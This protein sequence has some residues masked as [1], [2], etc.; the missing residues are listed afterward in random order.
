MRYDIYIDIH[1][2]YD[3]SIQRTRFAGHCYRSEVEI[4][5]DVLLWL[6]NHESTKLGRQR[7]TYV[8]ELCDDTGQMIRE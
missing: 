8:K 1:R 2:R 3:V 7:K 5:K 6:M 4:V